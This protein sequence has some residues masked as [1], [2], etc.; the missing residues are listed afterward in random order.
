MPETAPP[1]GPTVIT[2]GCR[3]NTYESEVMRRHARDAGLGD[4]VIVNTCAVTSEAVRGA[5]QAIRR[6][7]K[8]NPGAPIL[9]TGC[10]AQIDPGAFAA[11]PEVTRVIG[12]HEKMQAETWAPLD[13]LGG[14][15]KVR[16]NDIMGVRET[17]AHLID[18]MDGRARAYVQ[19]QNGCD[20]R[21]TFCIIPYGRGNSR[22]VPAG[23]VVA[24]V[25][26]LVE[27][28]HYEVVLTGVDLTS[29]GADLPGAPQ[30]G[31]LVQRILKLVPELRQLRIS[32]IDAIEMDE[33]LIAA[34]GEARVA[35]YL[36]LSLQHGDDLILKRMKR[37]HG[38][39][40]AIQLT[41]RLRAVR[42]DIA[43]GADIIAGFPTETEAHFE[44][45]VK[46]V[47][48]CGLSFLHVFPYSPRPGTPAAKMPQVAK[49]LI[50]ERAARLRAFGEAA[51]ARHLER[52][53]G[54]TRT[55]LLE[56][57][58]A[59]RLPDFTPVR[60]TS[61]AGECGQVL[62]VR[63]TGHDGKQLLGTHLP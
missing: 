27:T 22:S 23:E 34:L 60:L 53:V 3:L 37:R 44:S 50:K 4:A 57:G 47:E 9:V 48:E 19:V 13:L 46:L 18:G 21:C 51:L 36:H 26:R 56:R 17:A 6:A 59:A 45:S 41:E 61:L 40:Q 5:R 39:D 58:L 42:P 38:R 62:P 43:L 52:H 30:L 2:L 10:A 25:R 55:A 31:N 14:A 12:N 28:G 11:M 49:P 16:V 7:A 20:H 1:S 24:Q 54:E 33:A 32:S 35:P 8:E 15:E 63:I 29:W